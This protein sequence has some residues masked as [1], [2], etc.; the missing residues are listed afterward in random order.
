MSAS[1]AK[2]EEKGSG[3]SP[4]LAARDEWNERYRDLIAAARNWRL[5]A[6]TSS[7][8]ALVAVLGLIVIGA[9]PKVIPYIVAVDNLGKVVSQGTAVQ[10]SVAD[11]RLKRAALWSWVQDW[12]MVSSDATVE[13]KAIERVYAQIGNGTPAAIRISDAYRDWSPLKL[14]QTETISVNVRALYASS[15]DSYEVEW[16]ET[17]FDL[18]GEQ[19]GTQNYKGVITI[20]IHPPEDEGLAR[21]NPLGIYVTNVS[22]SKVL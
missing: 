16:T 7:V 12:R 15:K 22:W 11:D 14:T 9:K 4:Y 3:K 6:V 10:A 21:V 5:L 19:I 2:V 1:L 8:V 17:T 18:K 20:S 13:K